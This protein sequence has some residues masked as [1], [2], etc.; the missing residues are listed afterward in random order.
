MDSGQTASLPP[1]PA[2]PPGANP[3]LRDKPALGVPTAGVARIG[4]LAPLLAPAS[5]Q[6][7]A[8]ACRHARLDAV[9]GWGNKPSAR[10]AA[11]LAARRGVPLWRCEDGFLRSLGLGS[12]GPPLSLVLDDL[13]IYYDAHGPSRLE[14]LIAGPLEPGARARARAL[15]RLW[16]RERLSK[17]IGGRESPAPEQPFVLLVD[18]TAGDLSIA[19]GL[20]D[21]SSFQAMLQAALENHPHQRIVVKVH[22][23]V[24]RGRRRGHFDAAELNDTRLSIC[25]DGG[26]PAALLERADAV[27]VV[28]SQLGFEA[29]LWGREVHCFGM[30]FY[31]G[32]GLT[33]DRLPAPQRRR[34][35]S[36]RERLI[37][38][39]LVAYPTYLDPNRGE[40][41][42]PERLMAVL[43]LQQRRRLELPERIEAFGFKPWKQPILRRFLAGSAVRFRRRRSR[44]HGWGHTCAIWGRDPGTGVARRLQQPE[45]P[46][47]LRIEDGF[48]RS[49]G[50]GANLIAPVSWVVDRRGLYYDA[51]GPSDLEALLANHAFSEAERA[52]GAALRRRLLEAA[53]TKYNLAAPPWRRPAHARRVVLVAGQ[54]ESDAS[55]RYGAGGLRTNRALLEAVRAAEPEAWLVYKPHPD[56]VAGLRVEREGGFDPH[57]LCDEVLLEA[58]LDPLYA[59]VDAVHVL[60]S[61]AGFE[62]LLRGG[63]VHTWGL[64]FYA[65]WGLSKDQIASPRRGRPLQLDELVW[66]CLIAYP[67]YVSRRSGLFIEAEEA[68]EELE[69]WRREPAGSLRLWQRLFR[70]WGQIRERFFTNRTSRTK[71]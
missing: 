52:R 51:A 33:H 61:L 2:E 58:A 35:G 48:L 1:L 67:R 62:A 44:P 41:C 42:S 60:T 63:E 69:S 22:P 71:V 65:G 29:V 6:L 23:E 66:G 50:L 38:A 57:G 21:A 3:L 20:A 56:V 53:I 37:H 49:V 26:H 24:A 59:A 4:T 64:P 40:P 16:C 28:T 39:A 31:A 8:R 7:G 10:R 27:Y 34:G 5:L 13:G 17:Y 19:G 25:D 18:Q 54:V 14:T 45:P 46:E 11:R 12:D 32:W 9:L 15:A 30:P 68:I 70:R 36:D 47:L 55:I 43:G